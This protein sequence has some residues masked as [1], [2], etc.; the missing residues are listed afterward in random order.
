MSLF[1]KKHLVTQSD[2]LPGR[3]TPMPVATLHAVNEH[4][5]TNVPVGL[6]IDHFAMGCFWG[7]ERPFGRL[8]VVYSTAAGSMGGYS[9]E[10]RRV[11]NERRS[12]WLPCG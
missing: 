4:S 11:G 3:N 1:D 6:E 12:R 10:E 5:M 7:V 9:T 8:P 2:A